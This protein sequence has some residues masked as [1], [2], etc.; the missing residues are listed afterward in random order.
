M[1]RSKQQLSTSNTNVI[2][3]EGSYGILSCLGD[4]DYPYAVPLNYVYREG[5]LYMHSAKNGHKVDAITNHAKVSFT[6]VGKDSIVS[7]EYTTYF[8]SVIA[9]GRARFATGE[10]YKRAFHSLVDKYAADQPPEERSK[11]VEHCSQAIIIAID[12]D[13]ITGKQAKELMGT[14]SI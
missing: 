8:S 2:L 1:R 10:E 6:V 5:K 4:D 14:T 9:F 11:E 12:I 3:D 13:H 7:K